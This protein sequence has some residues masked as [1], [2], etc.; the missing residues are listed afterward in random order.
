MI[1]V[2]YTGRSRT[3]NHQLPMDPCM[4]CTYCN[5]IIFNVFEIN[6]ETILFGLESL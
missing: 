5:I 3:Y 2:Y 4:F 6:L 1:Y